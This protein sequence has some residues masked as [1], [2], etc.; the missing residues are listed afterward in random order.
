VT[1]I[2]SHVDKR[3]VEHLPSST[4]QFI[5]P[6]KGVVAGADSISLNI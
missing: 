4:A 3:I 1:S 6:V 5:G 2:E